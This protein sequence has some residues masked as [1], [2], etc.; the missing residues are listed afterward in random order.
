MPTVKP[1]ERALDILF[2]VHLGIYCQL[3][4]LNSKNGNHCL[5]NLLSAWMRKELEK[6]RI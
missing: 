1:R 2:T 3:K 4:F 5:Y 6:Q